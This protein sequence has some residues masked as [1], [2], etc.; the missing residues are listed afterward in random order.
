MKYPLADDSA[1]SRNSELLEHEGSILRSLSSPH[2]IQ[3][4]GAGIYDGLPYLALDLADRGPLSDRLSAG[5]VGDPWS[6]AR[7][8]AALAAALAIIHGAGLVHR[9]VHPGNLLMNSRPSSSACPTSCTRLLH[10]DEAIVLADFGIACTPDQAHP[11]PWRPIGTPLFRAPEQLHP[12]GSISSRTDLFAATATI[13]S[14]ISGAKPPPPDEVDSVLVYL[15][16]AWAAFLAKGM[17]ADPACRFPS[18][19]AWNIALVEA[20]TIDLSEAGLHALP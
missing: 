20:I 5:L 15:R 13:W 11:T 16:P 12:A 14:I 18:A 8:G 10:D 17:H 9:D 1:V 6:T 3:L 2:I 4:R 19:E 7:I